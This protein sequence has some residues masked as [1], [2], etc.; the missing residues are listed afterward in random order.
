MPKHLS[1]A[2]IVGFAPAGC[3][4]WTPNTA[5]RVKTPRR[6]PKDTPH[7]V[8]EVLV[9]IARLLGRQAAREW[10]QRQGAHDGAA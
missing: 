4:P 5:P 1:S 8:H 10:F 3:E 2:E 7:L 6:D 9:A